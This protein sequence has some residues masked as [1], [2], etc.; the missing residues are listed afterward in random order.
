MIISPNQAFKPT[1][2]SSLQ[3]YNNYASAH[4]PQKGNTKLGMGAASLALGLGETLFSAYWNAKQQ[5]KQNQWNLEQ[6]NA[7]NAYNSPA[8]Q[9]GRMQ[10][11][12]YG[13]IAAM[14]ALA[15]QPQYQMQ[16]LTSAGVD[17][18]K[19]EWGSAVDAMLG[20]STLEQNAFQFARTNQNE[21]SR[22]RELMKMNAS[23]IK[24]NSQLYNYNETMNHLHEEFQKLQNSGLTLEQQ[25][26]TLQYSYLQ[27][28]IL[29]DPKIYEI[30]DDGTLV[31]DGEYL[32]AY[33]ESCLNGVRALAEQHGY[34]KAKAEELA[35]RVVDEVD[36]LMT[37]ANGEAKS[38]LAQGDLDRFNANHKMDENNP[39]FVTDNVVFGETV[40]N[41][42]AIQAGGEA[43]QGAR[44][45]ANIT[46]STY[47][48][49]NGA[50]RYGEDFG[51]D[52]K[53]T[54][55][56]KAIDKK[57][58]KI[59]RSFNYYYRYAT[60]RGKSHDLAIKYALRVTSQ[61]YGVPQSR[62][63]KML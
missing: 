17:T 56:E 45:A 14:E 8:A 26:Q 4:L 49:A 13:S 43:A 7:A 23:E 60:V 3:Q 9:L 59:V 21:R 25:V 54:V 24:L 38:A 15:G 11:A 39:Q 2:I 27:A 42:N 55:E 1:D 37:H 19:T 20:Q 32:K 34:E 10:S 31:L 29:A 57:T 53:K 6:Q 51:R 30:E 22:I 36:Y 16:Q 52:A 12:G 46:N 41:Y 35:K 5:E 62:L 61:R 47:G 48:N 18:P 44:E 50:R 40:A 63:R 58:R 28:S 33:K